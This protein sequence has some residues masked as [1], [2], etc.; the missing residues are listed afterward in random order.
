MEDLRGVVNLLSPPLAMWAAAVSVFL[1]W[2]WR[3]STD[4]FLKEARDA[5]V[6]EPWL[7]RFDDEGRWPRRVIRFCLLA[8][9]LMLAA[10]V[11]SLGR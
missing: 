8:Y 7:Q 4:R 5:G 9:I 1:L 10:Y 3:L 2:E 6:P 11:C